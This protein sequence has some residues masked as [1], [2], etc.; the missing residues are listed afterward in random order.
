M[1]SSGTVCISM[2]SMIAGIFGMNIPYTW[3][4]EHGYVF[5]WVSNKFSERMAQRLYICSYVFLFPFMVGGGPHRDILRS[6]VCDCTV[7]R[8]V[9]RACGILVVQGK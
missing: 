4:D 2:Y 6:L 3:N 7:V 5:K 8:S 9:Q 1:L